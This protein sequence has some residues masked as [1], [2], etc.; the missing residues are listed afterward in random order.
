MHM[1]LFF[2]L[3]TFIFQCYI[4]AAQLATVIRRSG[5]LELAAAKLLEQMLARTQREGHDAD[6]GGLVRAV[7]EYAGVTGVQIRDVMS[8]AE[9]VGDE[10]LWIVAHAAS[11][12]IV[13][14]P[15]RNI[16]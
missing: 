12:G 5:T 4:D 3:R 10:F 7:E 15:A 8:L 1:A 11:A 16:R 6:G 2:R 9:G 13:E 14:A